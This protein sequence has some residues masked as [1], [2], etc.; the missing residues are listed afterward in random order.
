MILLSIVKNL[1][2]IGMFDDSKNK[3]IIS[4]LIKLV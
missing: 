3:G 4:V 1:V 2:K